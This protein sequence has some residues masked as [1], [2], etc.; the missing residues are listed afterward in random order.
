MVFPGYA[1]SWGTADYVVENVPAIELARANRS[2]RQS[3]PVAAKIGLH[4]R[5]GR[6]MDHRLIL[7]NAPRGALIYQRH[8]AGKAIAGR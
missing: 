3:A 1:K 7:V 2:A 5:A 8:V 4:I 6:K